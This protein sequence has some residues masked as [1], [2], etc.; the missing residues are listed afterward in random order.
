MHPLPAATGEI[1]TIPIRARPA[2]EHR[3]TIQQFLFAAFVAGE[4]VFV[5]SALFVLSGAAVPMLLMQ[6]GVDA[7][8]TEGSAALRTLFMGIYA[9]AGMLALLRWKRTLRAPLRDPLTILVIGFA[10]LSAIWSIEPNLTIQRSAALILTTAFGMYVAIRYSA[11]AL[12]RC[13]LAALGAAM[14]LSLVLGIFVPDLGISSGATAGSWQG[15]YTHKNTLGKY[16]A[17][18]TV[19]AIVHLRS[20]KGWRWLS[21]STLFLAL[22]LLALSRSQTAAIVLATLLALLP[23]TSVIRW[24]TRTGAPVLA[25]SLFLA[26]AVGMMVAA[27]F[28]IALAA[29]GRDATFTGRT[30]LWVAVIDAA[31]DRPALGVGYSAFWASGG[32]LVDHVRDAAGWRADGA[33][34]GFLD[35]WLELGAVGL[36]LLLFALARA[37]RAAIRLVRQTEASEAAL[38]LLCIAFVVLTNL[39]EGGILT[40]NNLV[41]VL[42]VM[43]ATTAYR[44]LRPEHLA[45]AN[46]RP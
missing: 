26:G 45:V 32:A 24:K 19:L 42:F 2:P 13:L 17:L 28:E 30:S 31:L 34:N 16:A 37:T 36:V 3:R 5:V 6:T 46:P 9:L 44:Y 35:V 7:S 12:L 29:I 4:T 21:I 14:L 40:Q 23:M 22:P 43:S 1:E 33:H 11:I 8:L 15:A 10:V 27:N 39:S 41:W 20:E 38:P 25:G 18:T